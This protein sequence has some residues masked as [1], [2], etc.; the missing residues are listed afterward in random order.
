MP[1]KR[2][3]NPPGV[4]SSRSPR[5]SPST[6]QCHHCMSMTLSIDPDRR[7]YGRDNKAPQGAI[8]RWRSPGA[9]GV[10]GPATAA[11]ALRGCS[12]EQFAGAQPA[13]EPIGPRHERRDRCRR[14]RRRAGPV[15][16]CAAPPGPSPCAAPGRTSTLFSAGTPVSASVWKR[17][18][19]GVSAVTCRSF[20]RSFRMSGCCWSGAS[21]MLRGA[22]VQP[23]L[24]QGD[25][26]IAEDGEV[27]PSAL[28]I[29]RIGGAG[30]AAI[31]MGGD[32]R[33]EVAAGRE[34]HEAEPIAA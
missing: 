17:N 33:R 6:A 14:G 15:R 25:Y 19:G 29:D 5:A 12:G 30:V 9:S 13:G 28:A 16:R 21:S 27:R 20:D 18:V 23:A 2:M 31:D 32:G 4:A 26:R 8:G 7:H 11:R 34:T 10:A 1:K 3:K 22:A 24:G